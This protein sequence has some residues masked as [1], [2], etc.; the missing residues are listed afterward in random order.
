MADNIDC[1]RCLNCGAIRKIF[2]SE[3]ETEIDSFVRFIGSWTDE[4]GQKI[5]PNPDRGDIEDAL[6][7]ASED[8]FRNKALSENRKIADVLL[9]GKT[10]NEAHAIATGKA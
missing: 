4:N 9:Q 7:A 8:F 6:R 2:R 5:V 10:W 1:M 3:I